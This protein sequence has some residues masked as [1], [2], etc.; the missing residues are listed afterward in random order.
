[1]SARPAVEVHGLRTLRR[2]LKAAGQSLDK[3]FKDVH[4]QVAATV[5]AAAVPMTPV[6]PDAAGHVRDDVRGTGQAAAA[7]IRAG[8]ASRPYAGRLHYGDPDGGYPANPWLLNAMYA[9]QDRW[10]TDY[11][12]G[13]EQI[14][15]TIKG[16]PGP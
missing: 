14:L 5:V 12:R 3:D 10:M 4:A 9:T 6:G 1:M 2:T 16:D 15:Y 7:V 13:L 8:R 11:Q